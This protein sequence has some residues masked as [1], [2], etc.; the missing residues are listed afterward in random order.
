MAAL[1]DLIGLKAI[2]NYIG[3]SE[4]WC[5]YWWQHGGQPPMPVAFING[6]PVAMCHELDAWTEVLRRE[7]TNQGVRTK[8]VAKGRSNAQKRAK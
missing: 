4:R 5:Q 7:R 8:P 3:R 6:R 1:G 2:A